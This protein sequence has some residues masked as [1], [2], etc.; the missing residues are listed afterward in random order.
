MVPPVPY[1][2]DESI[3]EDVEKALRN[4]IRP[5]EGDTEETLERKLTVAAQKEEFRTLQKAGMTFTEYLKAMRDKNNDDA[6]LLSDAHKVDE[7]LYRD[8]TL[9]DEE[10]QLQHEQINATL[11]ARGLPE[12]TEDR[13]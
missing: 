2:S 7:E 13:D 9:S 12:M 1:I 8:A 10:Y 6:Q 11:R 5:E 4:V 3:K